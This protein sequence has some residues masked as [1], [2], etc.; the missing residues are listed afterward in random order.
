[1]A[2]LATL[3][4][5]LL[6]AIGAAEDDGTYSD[7]AYDNVMSAIDA[8]V[9]H[10]PMPRPLDEQD[11][12]ADPWGTDFAQFGP[13]HTAGKPKQH[14][15]MFTF[16]TFGKLPKKPLRVLEIQQEIHHETKDYNNVHLIETIDGSVK[17]ELILYGRYSIEED[18]PQRYNVDFYKGELRADGMTDA[19]LRQAFD[20]PEDKPLQ[21]EF[22][23]PTLHSDVVYCDEDM[24]INFGSLGGKYV[25]HRLKQ[26][27]VSVAA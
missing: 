20:L 5:N 13:R 2:D 12:V 19:D 25:L 3:K 14:E 23:S 16:L 24:R 10:T 9:V 8:L 22:K 15:N 17:A 6:D 1:M 4:T 21:F 26:P 27:F 7:A 18:T 11:K